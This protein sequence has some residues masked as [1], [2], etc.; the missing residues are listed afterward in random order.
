MYSHPVNLRTMEEI[1]GAHLINDDDSWGNTNP[2]DVSINT[3]NSEEM[4]TG[5]HVIELH[6]HKHK[7]PVPPDL[8]NEESNVPEGCDGVQKYQ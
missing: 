7:E 6:T 3:A 1:L 2:S 8:L 5:S 4:M